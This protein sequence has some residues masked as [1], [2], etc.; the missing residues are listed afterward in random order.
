M[1]G[2]QD[3]GHN[4]DGENKIVHFPARED[5]ERL[6]KE[7]AREEKKA[8][9]DR[10]KERKAQERQEEKWR[11]QYRAEQAV[12]QG[13]QVQ[14]GL[15]G[16]QPF[17]NLGRIPFFTRLVIGAFVVVQILQTLFFDAGEK[18]R[19]FYTLG[20][21]PGIYTGAE[22]WQMTGLISPVTS[23]FI[24]GGWM[25]LLFNIVM[26]L[27]MGVFFE[28]LF[29]ARRTALFFFV[30]GLAGDAF[31][32]LFSPFSTEPV[33]GA[34]GA[35]SGLFAVTFL[36]LHEQGAL[37]GIGSKR[38]VLPFILIWMAL[39][40]GM[41]MIGPSVAWQAHL[42]GFLGGLSLFFAWKKGFVRL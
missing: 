30:C 35:I 14:D 13:A 10:A 38:G 16:K 29:G 7:K 6:K 25:H 40:V 27:A 18:L 39:I 22:P 41:G 20:F 4:Q 12:Q 15:P 21:V 36:I 24:H 19:L 31:Y 3:N 33:V 23:L 8:G 9:Q 17:F 5:R 42:G 1:S 34:S 26:M 2:R 28:R 11:K 37:H 32:F